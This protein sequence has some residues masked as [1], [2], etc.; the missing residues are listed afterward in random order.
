MEDLVREAL[1]DRSIE[2]ITEILG[3]MNDNISMIVDIIQTGNLIFTLLL[4]SMAFFVAY[5]F[6]SNYE[7]RK[8]QKRIFKLE[9]KK[10]DEK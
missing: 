4:I 9:E 10:N 8:L 6:Y 2:Q 7:I 5:M 3:L 1:Q